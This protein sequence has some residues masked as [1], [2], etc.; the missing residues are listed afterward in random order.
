MKGQTGTT[1]VYTAGI[2]WLHVCDSSFEGKVADLLLFA[3]S[4][5]QSHRGWGTAS[6]RCLAP[7]APAFMGPQNNADKE[8]LHAGGEG[9]KLS[10]GGKVPEEETVSATS[11]GGEE[12]RSG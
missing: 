9:D 11:D 5:V 8:T 7:R 3:R 12:G 1:S 10:P 2:S 4:Q 6:G